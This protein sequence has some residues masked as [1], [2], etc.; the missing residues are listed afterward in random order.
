MIN[1]LNF[2]KI[3]EHL[4]D[5]VICVNENN[6]IKYLN[7]KAAN[8]IDKKG[9]PSEGGRVQDFFDVRTDK[10][11][12]IILDLIEEVRITGDSKGLEENA[13]ICI[14]GKIR[15]YISASLSRIEMEEEKY[16]V[17]NFREITEMK[18]TELEILD[19]KYDLERI[20]NDIPIGIAI[21]GINKRVKHINPYFRKYFHIKKNKEFLLF[22]D[23]I[24]CIY[25]VENGCG[26]SKNCE[27]CKIKQ[28]IENS[29]SKNKVPYKIQVEITHKIE[30]EFFSR[31]CEIGFI[32]FKNSEQDEI[33]LTIEDIIE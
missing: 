6:A 8:I 16:V 11:G 31:R 18:K 21:V 23:L 22:G 2:Y 27:N 32:Q 9:L 4:G 24:Q 5:G 12:S 10:S 1:H 15:T 25:A 28:N 17:I 19:R 14:T 13:Y 33:M 20:F 29:M 30:N 26:K 7:K 3:L